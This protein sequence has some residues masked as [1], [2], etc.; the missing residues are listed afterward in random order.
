MS[1]FG[2]I[3]LTDIVISVWKEH[4]K[5]QVTKK[6]LELEIRQNNGIFDYRRDVVE[7]GRHYT[8]SPLSS[9]GSRVNVL[10]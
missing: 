6:G 5:M 1:L 9:F 2:D 10:N 8:I 7:Q 3:P 4:V